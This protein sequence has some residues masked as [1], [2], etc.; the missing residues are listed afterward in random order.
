[1]SEELLQLCAYNLGSYHPGEALELP[2]LFPRLFKLCPSPL[3][4]PIQYSMTVALPA[5][6]TL[7]DT[8]QPFPL[9]TPTFHSEDPMPMLLTMLDLH[10]KTIIVRLAQRNTDH[11][12]PRQTPKDHSSGQ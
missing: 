9:D 12:I 1:M 11:A 10:K 6:S 4:L 8:H 3:I 5:M 2:K 7:R